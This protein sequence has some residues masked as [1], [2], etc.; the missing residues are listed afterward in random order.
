MQQML[1]PYTMALLMTDM[2]TNTYSDSGWW[3]RIQE[4]F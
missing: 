2:Q 3:A 1:T 4:R